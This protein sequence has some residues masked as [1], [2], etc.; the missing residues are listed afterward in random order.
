MSFYLSSQKDTEAFGALLCQIVTDHFV[1]FLKG[2]L[3]MGKTSMVRGFLQSMGYKGPVKSPTYTIVEE[4]R[5]SGRSVF[6]FDLYRLKDPE[7]LHWMGFEDY[8]KESAVVFIEWPEMGAG[9]LPKPNLVI[10]F[11]PEGEGRKINID[12]E[13]G[14]VK[15]NIKQLWKNNNILL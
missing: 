15:N 2:D 13:W 12:T 1:V 8:L 5:L 9:L 14:D 6:H 7:E 11:T 10:E 3:G 4:Y